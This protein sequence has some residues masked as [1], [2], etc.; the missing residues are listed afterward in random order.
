MSGDVAPQIDARSVEVE[1]TV[2][3]TAEH[4]GEAPGSVHHRTVELVGGSPGIP[5][6]RELAVGGGAIDETGGVDL[7][8]RLLVVDGGLVLE[9]RHTRGERELLGGSE[10]DARDELPALEAIGRTHGRVVDGRVDRRDRSLAQR[11]VAVAIE[12]F[13][14]ALLEPRLD[15]GRQLARAELGGDAGDAMKLASQP[16][17]D[18]EPLVASG[19]DHRRTHGTP[20]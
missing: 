15:P 7:V 20:T 9:E 5:G 19:A 12:A 1:R 18:L 6:H 17:V 11:A 4:R 16:G 14:V 2:G 3:A 13:A 8:D 10:R